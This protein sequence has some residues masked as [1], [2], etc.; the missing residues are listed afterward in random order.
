VDGGFGPKLLATNDNLVKLPD[1][2]SFELGAMAT[3]AGL[4]AYHAITTRP[5]R[6]GGA[7]VFIRAVLAQSSGWAA[8]LTGTPAARTGNSQHTSPK[9]GRNEA[10]VTLLPVLALPRT[11]SKPTASVNP[12]KCSSGQRSRRHREQVGVVNLGNVRVGTQPVTECVIAVGF[13]DRAI[14]RVNR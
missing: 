4:T 2:V 7:P 8:A 14:R 11:M 12:E 5:T 13:E 6:K 3:D 1:E 9:A 10:I